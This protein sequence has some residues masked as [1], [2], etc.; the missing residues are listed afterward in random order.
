MGRLKTVTINKMA[1]RIYDNR[2]DN[3][4]KT[5]TIKIILKMYMEECR[6]ALLRGERVELLGIG[7]IIPK[8]K[9]HRS[10]YLPTCNNTNHENA[11]YTKMEMTRMDSLQKEMNETLLK[12]IENGIYGLEELPF[13]IQQINNLK[14]NGYIP[15]EDDYEEEEV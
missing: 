14:A 4:V 1:K 10:C 2:N 9:T 13:D 5:D 12:N 15:T 11:P 3:I 6:K 8:V 7:T